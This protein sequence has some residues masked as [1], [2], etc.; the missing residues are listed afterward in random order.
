[1][2]TYKN[3]IIRSLAESVLS[4]E[5][6]DEGAKQ[7]ADLDF[8]DV[9]LSMEDYN[10]GI[11][12]FI[13]YRPNVLKERYEEG[14][15]DLA[16]SAIV[17]YFSM[18]K[19]DECN[20]WSVKMVAAEKGYGPVLYDMGMSR[21]SPEGL[22]ADRRETTE[23]AKRIWN[24]M[25][26]VRA[27]DYNIT[28]LG[29]NCPHSTGNDNALKYSFAIKDPISYRP[30]IANHNRCMSDMVDEGKDQESVLETIKDAGWSFFG[31]RLGE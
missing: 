28:P 6:L 3:R 23:A 4:E 27:D 16:S 7:I 30:L 8:E 1:M 14:S 26:T 13:L 12:K 24:Y 18:V 11:C 17:G 20:A 19:E 25:L 2:K 29:A 15:Y 9:A 21:I 31:M 5:L 22:M 10:N